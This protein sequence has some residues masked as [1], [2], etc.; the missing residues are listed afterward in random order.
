MANGYI[1]PGDNGLAMNTDPRYVT[2]DA[3]LPVQPAAWTNES[4]PTRYRV[5]MFRQL[6][7]GAG[8]VT[9]E[10]WKGMPSTTSADAVTGAVSASWVEYDATGQHPAKPDGSTLDCVSFTSTTTEPRHVGSSDIEAKL[11]YLATARDAEILALCM[12]MENDKAFN[13]S[14]PISTQ[15]Y[16]ITGRNT[17]VWVPYQSNEN[18]NAWLA[19]DIQAQNSN[20]ILYET[21]QFWTVPL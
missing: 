14:D 21:K 8:V 11:I 20:K 9:S 15:A 10:R 2:I 5:Q 7:V 18:Y 3:R 19:Q 13:T 4:S 12:I 6:T 17:G 16:E 1:T